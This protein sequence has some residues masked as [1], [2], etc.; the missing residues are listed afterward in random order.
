MFR[1]CV[2]S[3]KKINF[4]DEERSRGAG[5]AA[6]EAQRRGDRRCHERNI[7]D[8]VI[9][10]AF[11]TL[12]YCDP[13]FPQLSFFPFL[14]LVHALMVNTRVCSTATLEPISPLCLIPSLLR[15]LTTVIEQMEQFSSRLGE[16]SSRVESTHEHTAQGLEQ[17]ARRRDE[18]LRSTFFFFLFLSFLPLLRTRT[19]FAQLGQEKSCPTG[20]I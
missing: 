12:Q 13:M 11:S 1:R 10:I 3:F 7:A 9:L 4:G 17:G 14:T 2:L 5:A 20:L 6:E 8:Q 19:L 16:L 18:Q 15:S